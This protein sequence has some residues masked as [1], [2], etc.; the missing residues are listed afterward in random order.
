MKKIITLILLVFTLSAFAQTDQK[1][2]Y[3]LGMKAIKKMEAGEIKE[4]ITMLEECQT[5]APNDINY[6]YEIA[7]AHYLDKNYKEALKVLK[8]LVNHPKAN[9]RIHQMLGNT[10]DVSGKPAKAIEAYETGL[11]LFPTSGLLY[12]ERGNMDMMKEEYNTALNFY[13]KGIKVDPAFPSN[14]Y[15]ATKIYLSSTEEIW[16]MIYGEI[17]VNMERNTVRT[18]EISK[19]LYDRYKSEIKF[20]SDSTATVSFSQSATINIAEGD[21]LTNLK[22]P[23]SMIAYEPMLLI[24]TVGEKSIDLDALD[25]IRTKFLKMYFDNGHDKTYPNVL[26]DYQKL[27]ESE[28]HFSCYNHWLLMKGDE[29]AFSTWM[30]DHKDE[31]DEFVKWFSSNPLKITETQNFHSS[32]Y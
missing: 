19:F 16:G 2:A 13:E 14:Y 7:Y 22:L 3:D 25:R 28:G 31:W 1:K 15:W 26:F 17:F 32:Q 6:P 21:D 30:N 9:A 11:K 29:A 10:Y 27:I 5:L 12:L 23:F 8:K 20:T 4:A 18:E 24:A